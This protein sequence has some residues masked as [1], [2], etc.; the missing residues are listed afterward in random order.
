MGELANAWRQGIKEQVT[1]C[2][3]NQ[4]NKAAVKKT[5]QLFDPNQVE[6]KIPT[7]DSQVA[8]GHR[9]AQLEDRWTIMEE[10]KATVCPVCSQSFTHWL[11]H[12]ILY[13]KSKT[14]LPLRTKLEEQAQGPLDNN[15]QWLK[16]TANRWG[17]P[18][19]ET[20]GQLIN[21][22]TQARA[23]EQKKTGADQEQPRNNDSR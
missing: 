3:W 15:I 10:M 20:L 14:I 7:S 21:T 12:I 18:G 22:W 4:H 6:V 2:Y 13:C 11:M 16:T 1:A 5:L 17:T 19:A 23:Q 8:R 9:R